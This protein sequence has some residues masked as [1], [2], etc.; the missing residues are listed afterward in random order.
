MKMLTLT[1]R[2]DPST[3][4]PTNGIISLLALMWP[5]ESSDYMMDDNDDD[6]RGGGDGRMKEI[7]LFPVDS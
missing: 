3:D 2:C 7:S 4:A 5:A 6:D 1:T